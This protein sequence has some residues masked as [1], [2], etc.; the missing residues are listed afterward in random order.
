MAVIASS[1]CA[2]NSPVS[3]LEVKAQFAPAWLGRRLSTPCQTQ[4]EGG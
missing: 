3:F 4:W 1:A 2:A